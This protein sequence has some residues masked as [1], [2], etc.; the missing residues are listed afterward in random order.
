MKEHDEKI[1]VPGDTETSRTIVVR[2]SVATHK[3]LRIRVAES[4]TS[5]QK[6]VESLIERELQSSSAQGAGMHK[7]ATKK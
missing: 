2:L 3:T 5:I 6:W 4:D 7:A 1:V